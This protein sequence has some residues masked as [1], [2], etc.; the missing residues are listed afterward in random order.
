M[1]RARL[2]SL[3]VAI[4]L[5]AVLAATRQGTDAPPAGADRGVAVVRIVDGDTLVVTGGVRVRL[6]GIDTPES[7]DPR[8][9]VECFGT[10]AAAAL[11][12]LVPPGTPVRLTYD[13]DRTDDFGRTL[14]YL[15][16]RP[17]G[18]FV[19]AA[20][21]EQGYAHAA[22]HPPNVSHAG[23]FAA[24]AGQARRGNA[25]LWSACSSGPSQ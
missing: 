13:V 17:D 19:N 3:L 11:G 16:R 24:L 21:V 8:R 6:I 2:F 1:R 9:P 4:V 18:L 20:L 22:T 10:E 14:A 23:E 5:A 25:G 7:V 12:R 15:Y